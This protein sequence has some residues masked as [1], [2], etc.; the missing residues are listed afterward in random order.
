[1]TTPRPAV[2]EQPSARS[3]LMRLL[4]GNQV[5]QAI[6]VAAK[7]QIAELLA[8]GAKTGAELAQAIGVD[9]SALRRPLRALASFGVFAENEDGAFEL[10]AAAAL[11][12]RDVPG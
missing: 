6:H 2:G 4:V 12:R 7:L 9:E 10:T 5:Q 1:M 8:A 11:L 3:A